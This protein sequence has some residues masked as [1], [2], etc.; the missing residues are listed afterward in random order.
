MVNLAE[1]K[2]KVSDVIHLGPGKIIQFD[3][4]CDGMIDMEAGGHKI[5]EGEPVKVG[6][7]FGLRVTAIRLPDERYRAVTG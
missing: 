1:T 4:A 3:K 6:D 2:M 5:A 7:K